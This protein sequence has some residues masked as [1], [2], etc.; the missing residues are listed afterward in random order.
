MDGAPL[1][2]SERQPG[3]PAALNNLGLALQ[4]QGRL[5]E[6]EQAFRRA[7]AADPRY[8]RAR[9]NLGNVLRAQGRL[10]EAVASLRTALELQPSYPK[11]W[12]ALGVALLESEDLAGAADCLRRAIQLAPRYAK[13]LFNYGDLLARLDR[14]E[15]AIESLR[16]AIQ[17]DPGH[18]KAHARLGGLLVSRF[19]FGAAERAFLRV[20][21]IDPGHAEARTGLAAC[22]A[23]LCDWRERE[24]EIAAVRAAVIR[25][26]GK[27]Q[28]SPLSPSL[29]MVLGLPAAEQLAIARDTAKRLAGRSAAADLPP[30]SA[31]MRNGRLR[32]GYLSSDFRDNALAHL[33]R[34]LYGL[35]DRSRFKV[36]GYS[37]GKDDGSEYRR[38]IAKDCD[39]F[40]DLAAAAPVAAA[41]RIREDGIGILVDLTG[42][43]AG[44]RPE[45]LALRPAPIQATYLYPGTLGGVFTD[46][47]LGDAVITPPQHQEHFGES[48]VLLPGCY[49]VNDHLQPIAPRRFERQEHGL[50][51]DAFVFCSFNMHW[52]IEPVIWDVWMRILAR[53]PRGVLWLQDMAPPARE[54]LRR[55]AEAR[56]VRSDRLVFAPHLKKPEHLARCG[57]AD[58]FL[59]TWICNAHTTASDALWSGVPVLTCPG[60]HLPARVAASLLHAAGLPE[61]AV[62]DL[63]TYEETAVR[64][65]QDREALAGLRARVAAA[66]TGSPLYDTPRKVRDLERAFL[67]MWER[68]E[69]GEPPAAIAVEAL[70]WETQ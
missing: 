54:N 3:F 24:A 32:L 12:N 58:L 55:E 59:D 9:Y 33:T 39:H 42:F 64:L 13:A 4:E 62:A 15:E 40:V 67:A 41:R 27:G 65:A 14:W 61:L 26:L 6:A 11:A 25:C 16:R 5:A 56:G 49:Q 21:E 31:A 29:A 51:D 1:P 57:L 63:S 8:A 66:R 48:L 70:P 46:Y 47:F 60:D 18:A 2:D 69:K 45:I 28:A 17:A 37:L 36:F 50:P 20:V 52:K 22:R 23:Q 7:I 68:H 10:A 30:H 19:Q 38:G 34:R 44:S 43:A 35:H 53:V